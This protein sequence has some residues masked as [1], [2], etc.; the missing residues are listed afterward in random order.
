MKIEKINE[1]NFDEKIKNRGSVTVVDFY[2]DWCGPCK[3]LSPV[4][5]DLA[6]NYTDVEFYKVNVD[7]NPNLSRTYGVMSIPMLVIFKGGI[8]KDTLI[9]LRSKDEISNIIK[10][11]QN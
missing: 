1:G 11:L 8:A 10:G 3:M 5:E 4:L 7:E 9:G 6:S 2:A